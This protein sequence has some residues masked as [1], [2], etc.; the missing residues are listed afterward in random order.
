MKLANLMVVAVVAGASAELPRLPE[1]SRWRPGGI[2][3]IVET[4]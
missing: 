1:S 3:G 4:V 2:S